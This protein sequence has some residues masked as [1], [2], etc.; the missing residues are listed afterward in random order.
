MESEDRSETLVLIKPDAL[1]RGLE[2]E[3]VGRLERAGLRVAVHRP[4]RATRERL[5]RHLAHLPE[6]V[7]RRNA[8]DL[9]G[10]EMIAVI[11]SAGPGQDA[12][13][14]ARKLLGAT[15]PQDAAPGTIRGDLSCDSI[16]AAEAENRTVHNLAHASS[17]PADARAEIAN[18][19]GQPRAGAEPAPTNP[20]GR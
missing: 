8:D 20:T 15:S 14:V 6:A 9:E 7:R 19:L 13:G 3:I 11:L 2:G 18:W 16:A 5:E 12:V 10:E 17:S 1:A 4:V